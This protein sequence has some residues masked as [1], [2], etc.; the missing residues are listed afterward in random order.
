MTICLRTLQCLLILLF[1]FTSKRKIL[2][3]GKYIDSFMLMQS[4]AT[5]HY[6]YK[7]ILGYGYW[8]GRNKHCKFLVSCSDFDCHR[9][10]IWINWLNGLVRLLILIAKMSGGSE[11]TYMYIELHLRKKCNIYFLLFLDILIIRFSQR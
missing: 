7:H 6:I 8:M 10:G 11:D 5:I 1:I 9:F 2:K 3:I 4:S